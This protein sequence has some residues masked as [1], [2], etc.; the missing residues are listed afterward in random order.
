MQK[1]IP[2]L[3]RNLDGEEAAARLVPALKSYL[4]TFGGTGEEATN[5]QQMDT[6]AC[7]QRFLADTSVVDPDSGWARVLKCVQ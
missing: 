6:A 2:V 3:A 4:G 5:S 7:L 1:L